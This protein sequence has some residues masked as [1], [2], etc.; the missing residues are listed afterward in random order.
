MARVIL[1]VCSLWASVYDCFFGV[2][3]NPDTW[4][5]IELSTWCAAM[6]A[7]QGRRAYLQPERAISSL[8]HVRNVCTRPLSNLFAHALYYSG[9]LFDGLTIIE[10]M[11]RCSCHDPRLESCCELSSR[12]PITP[13]LSDVACSARVVRRRIPSVASCTDGT[14]VMEAQ[15][16]NALRLLRP[17]GHL[18][19]CDFTVLPEE[20]Q[21]RLSQHLWSKP[22]STPP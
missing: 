9:M 4:Y 10:P 18:C 1:C 13:H 17:G 21:W 22:C 5:F 3:T 14:L 20:G 19:V 11:C 16:K 6:L 7:T 15:V 8:S 12:H 2:C